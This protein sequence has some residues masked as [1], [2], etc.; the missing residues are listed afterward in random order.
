MF[1]RLCR[2]R[3]DGVGGGHASDVILVPAAFMQKTGE[4]HWETLL[5]ARAIENGCYIIAAA[6]VGRHN[7]TERVSFGNSLIV[8]PWG[9]VLARMDGVSEGYVCATLDP[10]VVQ[11][12]RADMPTKHHRRPDLYN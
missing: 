7:N 3:E 2:D 11:Q 8:S 9:E 6:Q 5:R 4:A 10:A 12:S 1:G